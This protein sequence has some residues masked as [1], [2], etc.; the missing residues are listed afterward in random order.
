LTVCVTQNPP[1]QKLKKAVWNLMHLF[2]FQRPCV[3]HRIS[4]LSKATYFVKKLISLSG[5]SLFEMLGWYCN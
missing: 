1:F 3:F 4:I 5:K 2:S